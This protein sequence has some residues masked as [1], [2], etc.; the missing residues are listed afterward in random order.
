MR[1]SMGAGLTIDNPEAETS[2]VF[3][4]R[5]AAFN[6]R[7]VENIRLSLQCGFDC[8]LGLERRGTA[9]AQGDHGFNGLGLIEPS[10]RS[11]RDD[12]WRTG[13]HRVDALD[14]SPSFEPLPQR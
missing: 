1:T 13:A 2:E 12:R 3:G 10:E 4:E 5:M 11:Q 8:P 9:A 6:R 7:D 14:A